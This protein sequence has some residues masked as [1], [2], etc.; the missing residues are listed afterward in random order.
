MLRDACSYS[1][2]NDEV[3]SS[4]SKASISLASSVI[5]VPMATAMSK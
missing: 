5:V 1:I 4:I 2:P 3:T